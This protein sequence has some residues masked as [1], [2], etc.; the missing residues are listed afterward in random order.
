MLIIAKLKNTPTKG[1]QNGRC[2]TANRCQIYRMFDGREVYVTEVIC[3]D[4]ERDHKE[5]IWG[6]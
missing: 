2:R 3:G 4:G 1:G 6:L 5:T